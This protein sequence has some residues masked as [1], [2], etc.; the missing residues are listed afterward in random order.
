MG[1]IYTQYPGD[2]NQYPKGAPQEYPYPSQYFSQIKKKDGLDGL[3]SCCFINFLLHN[4]N[5]C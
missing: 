3:D 1:D 4:N 2:L 5:V